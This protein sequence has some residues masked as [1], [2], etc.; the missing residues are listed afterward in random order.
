[1]EKTC[2]ASP[3]RLPRA[4]DLLPR[5][6]QS[7]SGI[8]TNQVGVGNQTHSRPLPSSPVPSQVALMAQLGPG[9]QPLQS[10]H[11]VF[12][13]HTPDGTKGQTLAEPLRS[14]LPSQTHPN[15]LE[16]GVGQ[17]TARVAGTTASILPVSI[18]LMLT[19]GPAHSSSLISLTSP[20]YLMKLRFQM[21]GEQAAQGH[22]GTGS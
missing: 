6:S 10:P 11:Q 16:K 21:T 15:P 2:P 19:V 14:Y 5:P 1:M 20:S 3:R 4:S 18:K 7:C 9:P 8:H 22:G 13:L 17:A 12:I